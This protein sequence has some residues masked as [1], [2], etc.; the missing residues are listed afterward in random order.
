MQYYLDY[1]LERTAKW[2]IKAR[3]NDVPVTAP[4]SRSRTL[5]FKVRSTNTFFVAVNQM[6]DGSSQLP[7]TAEDCVVV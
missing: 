2:K 4:F 6:H 5:K 7:T 1:K 3:L